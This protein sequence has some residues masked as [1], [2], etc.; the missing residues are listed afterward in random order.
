M[1]LK[2][3]H[4]LVSIDA[5]ICAVVF[6]FFIIGL[7]DG[8]VSSFNSGIWIGIWFALA[9]IM[10]GSLWL[11]ANGRLV[12]GMLLLLV[13]AIPSLLCGLFLL[14]FVVTGAQWR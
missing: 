5:L 1:K 3:F 2:L 7:A 4:V 12:P 8:S 11:K 10:A 13:L 14:L 9:A 6:V